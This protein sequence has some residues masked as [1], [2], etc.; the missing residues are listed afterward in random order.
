[1]AIEFDG[2]TINVDKLTELTYIKHM[3]LSKMGL[4]Q[5][6]KHTG[7]EHLPGKVKEVG[8]KG[9][10]LFTVAW[11]VPHDL[12][13]GV[14]RTELVAKLRA[15]DLNDRDRAEIGFI[16]YLCGA[17]W[18]REMMMFTKIIKWLEENKT[19]YIWSKSDTSA[20]TISDPGVLR[21]V[22]L[23]WLDR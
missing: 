23:T 20:F 19:P 5:H 22:R 18:L 7:K 1:M 15:L 6:L 2:T 9:S 16:G 14:I 4:E 17:H 10:N 13:P 21:R 11:E 8:Q 12:S 3:R